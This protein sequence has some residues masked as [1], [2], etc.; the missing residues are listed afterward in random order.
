MTTNEILEEKRK[1]QKR[2][3]E[4]AGSIRDYL[5]NAHRAAENLL[6]KECKVEYPK[7]SDPKP[8]ALSENPAKYATKPEKQDSK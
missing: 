5:V 7:F 4:Q 6:Q 8:S 3:S 2:L 1:V